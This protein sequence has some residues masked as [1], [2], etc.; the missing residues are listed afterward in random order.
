MLAVVGLFGFLNR[1]NDSMAT[2]LEDVPRAFARR[3]IGP[4]GWEPG[5]HGEPDR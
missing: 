4:G 5:K 2:E 1:W 3:T